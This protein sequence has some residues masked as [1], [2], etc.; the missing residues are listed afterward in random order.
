MVG[1]PRVLRFRIVGSKKFRERSDAIEQENDDPADDSEPVPPK[2]QPHE[3]PLRGDPKIS[4]SPAHG[5][6]HCRCTQLSIAD[7]RRLR[8]A[9]RFGRLFRNHSELFSQHRAYL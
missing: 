8:D 9:I 5:H 2:L 1:V 4:R 3:L 6:D 7:E